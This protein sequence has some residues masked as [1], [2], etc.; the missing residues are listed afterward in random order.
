MTMRTAGSKSRS[1]ELPQ[2]V[3]LG[4]AN[5][6]ECDAAIPR[7]VEDG[8][9]V[10][11]WFNANLKQGPSGEPFVES[12]TEMQCVARTANAL[13]A[14]GHNVVH[15]ISIGGWNAPHPSTAFDGEVWFKTWD[16]WNRRGMREYGWGGFDGFDWDVEG[17]DDPT[18]PY[19][20]ISLKTLDI[21]GTMSLAAKRNG[22]IV[23][24]APAQSY[25]DVGTSEF[26]LSL[27]QP[28]A[29]QWHQN[30]KYHGRNAYAYVLA[31]YGSRP[32][33]SEPTFDLV[34]LQLYEGWSSANYHI[35]QDP[36][37]HTAAGGIGLGEYLAQ[38]IARMI[39]GWSVD[40]P[41]TVTLVEASQS[42]A[43][44]P[45][46]IVSLLPSQIVIGF[47][48]GWAAADEAGKFLYVSPEQLGEALVRMRGGAPGTG[49]QVR[50]VGFWNI[51]D[52]GK[53][54]RNGRPVTFARTLAQ[55]MKKTFVP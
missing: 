3:L 33:A 42:V 7:A 6:C 38:L 11:V 10:L 50:G 43:E 28:P 30:F 39:D 40:F 54:D 35:S 25:L 19:N 47:A 14:S 17:N 53:S 37:A 51:K 21:M 49:V 1:R 32:D 2:S 55:Y 45:S 16:L 29:V 24:M 27:S 26:S 34:T 52:E 46:R 20:T 4:Y 31:K 18:S 23:T 22:Y 36:A 12:C 8:V 44:M 13:R 5:W 41:E 15:L 9:N 48:N